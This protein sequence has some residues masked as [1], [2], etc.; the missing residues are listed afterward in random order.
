MR[1]TYP[2]FRNCFGLFA[3]S[4]LRH[5]RADFTA[6]RRG[7]KDAP[8]RRRRADERADGRQFAP[9]ARSASEP[10]AGD[11]FLPHANLP[12]LPGGDGLLRLAIRAARAVSAWSPEIGR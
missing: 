2:H 4:P 10:S 6:V 7:V 1:G 11:D 12:H 3:E 9:F 5:L 8:C